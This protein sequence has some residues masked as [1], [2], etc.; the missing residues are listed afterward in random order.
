MGGGW[1]LLL[2]G[3]QSGQRAHARGT[4]E[5]TRHMRGLYHQLHESQEGREETH[6]IIIICIN[7]THWFGNKKKEIGEEKKREK[8]TKMC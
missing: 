8:M 6:H 1:L 4:P 7:C 3:G 5:P 2:H